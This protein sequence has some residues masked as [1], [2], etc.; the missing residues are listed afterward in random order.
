VAVVIQQVVGEFEFVE[1]DDLLHPLRALGGGVRV[2][3][4]P[5]GG[6]GV[7]LTGDQPR[8][9]VER[10]PGDKQNSQIGLYLFIDLYLSPSCIL[11]G[12]VE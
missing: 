11:T 6:R 3:V 4:D 12:K 1:G 5:P 2:V 9:A 7:S 10:I 8:G